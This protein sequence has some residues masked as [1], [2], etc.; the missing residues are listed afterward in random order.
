MKQ[1]NEIHYAVQAP[2]RTQPWHPQAYGHR[3][4]LHVKGLPNVRCQM[5]DP[6]GALQ[7][8]HFDETTN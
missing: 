4:T 1:Q 5:N 7:V 2:H 3:M 8:I 6:V